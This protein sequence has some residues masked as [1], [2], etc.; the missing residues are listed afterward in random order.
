[1][2][3]GVDATVRDGDGVDGVCV[4]EGVSGGGVDVAV[5]TKVPVG[6]SVGDGLTDRPL[7]GVGEPVKVG[8]IGVCVGVTVAV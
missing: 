6:G 8:L 5:G 1:V 2:A 3:E 7:E 4:G